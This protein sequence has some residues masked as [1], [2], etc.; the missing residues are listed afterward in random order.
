MQIN[1]GMEVIVG[2]VVEREELELQKADRKMNSKTSL[3][4]LPYGGM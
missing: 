3:L 1:L 4:I 2:G